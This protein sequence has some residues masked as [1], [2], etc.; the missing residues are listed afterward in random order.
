MNLR[1]PHRKKEPKVTPL[2]DHRVTT[3]GRRAADY[4]AQR[5]GPGTL[6]MIVLAVAGFLA[7]M[8]INNLTTQVQKLADIM[9]QFSGD[10]K[11]DAEWKRDMSR[12]RDE[13]D[14]KDAEQDE[15]LDGIQ[16]AR[17][18]YREKPSPKTGQN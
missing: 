2:D 4:D 12:W 3:K 1:F 8:T 11:A 9:S 5:R 16:A 6:F 15:K 14:K 18:L 10:M 17:P 7:A 13:K